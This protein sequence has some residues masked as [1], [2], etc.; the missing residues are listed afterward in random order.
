LVPED[1]IQQ[2]PGSPVVSVI[3]P[4]YNA[5]GH[6]GAALASVFAQSY[7]DFEV[8]VVNDGSPDSEQMELEIAPYLQHISY[9]KQQNRGPSA[10]RNLGIRH[11]RGE[12]L[13]FLDSDDAWLPN[14]L[15]EQ[16]RFL[17]S[18]P[19]LDMVYCDAVLEGDP[20][21]AGRTFMELYPSNGP[22]TFE[23]LLIEQTQVVTSGTVVRRMSVTAAGL[24]DEDLHCSEDHDL[25][26]RIVH[27]GGKIAYQRRALLRRNV[28]FD[29]QGSAPGSLLAGEIQSLGKLKQALDLRPNMRALL[30]AR[31]RKIQAAHDWIEG[32]EFLVAGNGDKASASLR[33]SATVAPTFQLHA[34]L[35]GLR[36]APRLTILAAQR[37]RHRNLLRPAP[38]AQHTSLAA[39]LAWRALANWSSQLISWA[40]LLVVVRLLSPA[41]FG[42]VGM[43]VVLYW[44]LKYLGDFGI[45][46]TVIRH[47]DLSEAT[48][49]QL[50]TM[51]VLFGTGSFLL[52][53]LFAWPAALFFKTSRVAPV[54]IVTCIALIPVGLRGVPE[55]LL[56]KEL[57]FKE[58]SLFDAIA[59]VVSAA[60]T[61][62]LAWL[63]FHYWALVLGNLLAE[64][65]RCTII[66]FVRPH[67]F[68]W[69]HLATIREPLT[70]GR[71]ILLGSFAW[72]T[73]NSLDN[74]TAGRVLGQSALGL[75]SMAWTLANVPLEKIVSLVSSL[76]P[77]YLARVQTD[78]AA[79]RNYVRTLT[80]AIA[81]VMFPASIGLGL[82]ARDAVPLVIGAKWNGMVA[83]LEVLCIYA[84]FRSVVPLLPKVLT[85]VGD[86]QFVMRV[87]VSGLVLMPIAF[88]IGS[89]WGITGI[90]LG[91]V[92]AYPLIALAHYWKVLKTIRLSVRE[93]VAALRPALDGSIAMAIAVW[94]LRRFL[95]ASHFLWVR[96]TVEIVCGAIVYIATVALLHRERVIHF[97]NIARRARKPKLEAQPGAVLL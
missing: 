62:L 95:A 13:A 81:L 88:Y 77:A 61:V 53:C 60:V 73:Y 40:A 83:P 29:S 74:V 80:E 48:L 90:A 9:L 23:S 57:R 87:E 38:S 68:A 59:V 91:W 44:Y 66:L 85:A 96:L 34:L 71:R 3:I 76:I 11:A 14:Y 97:L 58:L 93:Y 82:I 37:W 52:A 18:D 7:T 47:V 24:F 1:N 54:A 33:R 70:F 46:A 10:A 25:W 17:R 20:N 28:R 39:N 31:L 56:N 22:V 63:G 69:P 41:D 8:I 45:M 72:S 2:G 26:L 65:T 78:L 32:K 55:G 36:I 94:A 84:A 35:F 21:S 89:H 64:I 6:I 79:L 49:A 16:L 19:A 42:L 43:S 51:G 12:L 5:A 67:R 86:A 30:A 75:Y 4:A 92:F 15:A 27:S 50:N